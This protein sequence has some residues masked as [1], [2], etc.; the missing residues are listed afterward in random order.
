MIG[1]ASSQIEAYPPNAKSIEITKLA[2]YIDR[3]AG[4]IAPGRKTLHRDSLH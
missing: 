1:A 3:N 2:G 4:S